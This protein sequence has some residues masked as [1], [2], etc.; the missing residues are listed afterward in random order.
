MMLND[1]Q[2]KIERISK[3]EGAKAMTDKQIIIAYQK[4]LDENKIDALINVYKI[5]TV[6]FDKLLEVGNDR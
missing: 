1:S 5:K 3:F 2:T 6:Y 4:T